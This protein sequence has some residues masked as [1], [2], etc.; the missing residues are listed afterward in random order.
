MRNAI[1]LIV[2]QTI[3]S[4]SL[5]LESIPPSYT[6]P[7]SF[8]SQAG[9][10]LPVLR[11]QSPRL[12]NRQIKVVFLSIYRSLLVSVLH[13]FRV[14]ISKVDA[15]IPCLFAGICLAFLM[16]RFKA[17]SPEYVFFAQGVY[18]DDSTSSD[19]VENFCK[20]VDGIGFQ[21]LYRALSTKMRTRPLGGSAMSEELLCD[22]RRLVKEFGRSIPVRGFWGTFA[23]DA[24]ADTEGRQTPAPGVRIRH[25]SRLVVA[26]LHL[27][28]GT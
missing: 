24:M 27:V 4:I 21:R 13:D 2:V 18:G 10:Q 20:D 16:E 25:S 14:L 15:G 26:L 17:D 3:L 19:D 8:E 11:D 7:H 9:P 6:N 5:V 1:K 23:N 22:L 12:L 28:N